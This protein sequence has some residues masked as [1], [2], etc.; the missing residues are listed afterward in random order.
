MSFFYFLRK[1]NFKLEKCIF[2]PKKCIY[3]ISYRNEH[4]VIRRNTSLSQMLQI[5][6]N[7]FITKND[8]KLFT[9]L[10]A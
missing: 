3:F 4:P 9:S 7:N 6:T 1:E 8:K 10:S 5:K 2:L